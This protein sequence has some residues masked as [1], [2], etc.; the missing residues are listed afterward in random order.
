MNS[1][2]GTEERRFVTVRDVA[3]R[4]GVSI[5]TVSNYLSGTK[6]VSAATRERLDAVTQELGFVQNT[7]ARVMRGGRSDTVAL[8]VHDS[9]NPF[10]VDV[11][12]G[13]EDVAFESQHVVVV[14]NTDGDPEREEFYGRVLGEMRV[15]GVVAVASTS[16]AAVLQTLQ[17]AGVGVVRLGEPGGDLLSSVDVD[18]ER[19]GWLAGRHLVERG[20]SRVALVGGSGAE[21][22]IERRFQGLRRAFDEAGVSTTDTERYLLADHGAQSCLRLAEEVVT[23]GHQAVFCATDQI[24]IAVETAALR[25]GLSVPGHLAIVGYDDTEAAQ[26]AMVPITTIRQPRYE[27]GRTAA[28]MVFRRAAGGE[29]EHVRYEPE[30]IARASTSAL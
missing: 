5:G 8:L 24:A 25:T 1:S 11:A 10:F 18:D 22:Q 7:A 20:L 13:I 12:R 19:G 23:R 28:E 4:A 15:R 29:V 27:M 26:V 17:S 9:S 3:K 16:D 2:D 14:C 6:A 21:P 30:L